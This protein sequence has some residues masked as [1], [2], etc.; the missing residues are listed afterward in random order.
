[1]AISKEQQKSILIIKNYLNVGANA[2]YTDDYVLTTYSIAVEELI[3]N[4][5]EIKLLKT[6][7]IKSKSDG[8]QSVTFSD[9]IEAWAI[10]S[11]IKMLLPLPYVRAMG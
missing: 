11:N 10:T 6:L 3:E 9:G 4:A 5:S 8:V 1:M 7:G 2:K